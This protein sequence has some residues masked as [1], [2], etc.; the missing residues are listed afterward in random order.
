MVCTLRGS[1]NISELL[2][3]K[4]TKTAH[5]FTRTTTDYLGGS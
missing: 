2:T 4:Q 1:T 3:E 5:Q